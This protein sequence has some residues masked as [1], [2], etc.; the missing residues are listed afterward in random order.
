MIALRYKETGTGQYSVYLDIYQKDEKGKGSRHYE[1][2]K[3]YV[4]RD[5]SK[6]KR[7]AG[8]DAEKMELAQSIR[9]KRELELYGTISGLDGQT[10]RVNISLFDYIREEHRKTN[11]ENY[12]VLLKHIE[13]FTGRK[14]LV[15][16]GVTL[17]FIERFQ[18]H[19]LQQMSHNSMVNYMGVLKKFMR[20]AYKEEI[21]TFNAFVK[22]KMPYKQESDR[23]Y[24]ELH[25]IK[26]LAETPIH[27]EPHIRDAFLFSCF[28]GLRISDVKTLS[29]SQIQT[30]KDKKGNVHTVMHLR[31]LKTSR[32]T[33][34]ILKVPLSQQ[35]LIILKDQ[36]KKKG[37]DLIFYNLPTKNAC[38]NRLKEWAKDAGITKRMHFHVSRHTFATLGLTSGIDIYTVSKLMGHTRLEAT[39]VY[40]KIIDEK[41]LREVQKFPSFSIK[42]KR[43]TK[44]IKNDKTTL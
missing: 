21:I 12:L 11:R 44:S 20:K 3:I 42:K 39:Q 5:Y 1:F 24:F 16:S 14:D 2:L 40:A 43:L 35:A 26:K 38:N 28:A 15:F 37:C 34:Q 10:K 33:G 18:G 9:S 17:A 30:E 13:K 19:L 23:A 36:K 29:Y 4:S 6:S 7:I 8:E 27:F 41:K 22:Y 31:P 25:E 32:T